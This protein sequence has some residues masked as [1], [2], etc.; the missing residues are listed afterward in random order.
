MARFPRVR[1][2]R[3]CFALRNALLSAARLVTVVSKFHFGTAEFHVKR[4]FM[5]MLSKSPSEIVN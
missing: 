4:M 5:F 2:N 3:E 1:V